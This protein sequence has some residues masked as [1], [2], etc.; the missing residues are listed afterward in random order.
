MGII[1]KFYLSITL[2]VAAIKA[3]ISPTFS[4]ILPVERMT[5]AN[6]LGS[7]SKIW[8]SSITK[9]DLVVMDIV[10]PNGGIAA[11]IP[12]KILVPPNPGDWGNSYWPIS[13]YSSEETIIYTENVS[14]K[15]INVETGQITT[16]YN[17]IGGI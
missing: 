15:A 17:T 14:I 8:I 9:P 7:S 11:P 5:F 4:Y 2:T 10:N 12:D 1:A 16:S 13:Y 6:Q 3:A